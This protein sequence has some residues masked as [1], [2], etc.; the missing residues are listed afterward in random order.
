MTWPILIVATLCAILV[1]IACLAL[2]VRRL[3]VVLP[4]QIA[5]SFIAAAVIARAFSPVDYETIGTCLLAAIA[6]PAT[7]SMMALILGPPLKRRRARVG[8]RSSP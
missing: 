3:V 7:W 2:G 5:I 1:A 8:A 6:I 4:A